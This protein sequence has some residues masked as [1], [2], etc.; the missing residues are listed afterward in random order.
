MFGV[1]G[2][3]NDTSIA[4]LPDAPQCVAMYAHISSYHSCNHRVGKRE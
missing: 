1:F 2:S 4:I 3:K